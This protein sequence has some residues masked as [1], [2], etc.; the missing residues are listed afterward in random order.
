MPDHLTMLERLDL[1][2]KVFH[3]PA[4]APRVALLGNPTRTRYADHLA[5]I[6]AFEAP[7][8]HKWMRTP[9]LESFIDIAPR[10]DGLA[11]GDQVAFRGVYEWNEQ[12]GVVHW[13]HHD[14]SGEHPGG[15][16]R[17]DGRTVD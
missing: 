10:L 15:W 8:E 14:P 6:Y 13:T 2:T 9:G 3:G 16:L 17:Y 12:G 11:V 7:A 1:E 5:K 4:D